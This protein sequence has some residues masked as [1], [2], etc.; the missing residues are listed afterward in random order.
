MSNGHSLGPVEPDHASEVLETLA[1]AGVDVVNDD[2]TPMFN[3]DS[4]AA[5][6]VDRG[7]KVI[8][9]SAAFASVE[10]ER[11]IDGDLLARASQGCPPATA[12]VELAGA[13]GALDS[14]IFAYARASRA[15]SWRLPPDVQAAAAQRPD[16][17]VILT[18]LVAQ[19][20]KPLE[21]VCRAYGLSGLQTRVALETIRTGSVKSAT[22]TLGVSYHTAREALAEAMRRVRAPRL[23]ALVNRLT[24]LAFGVLPESDGASILG[25]LWGLTA[26]QAAIAGLVAE[27]LSRGGVA[28]ALGLSEAVVKKELDRVHLLLQV[29]TGAAL[30]RKIVEANALRWL[31]TATGGDIGFVEPGAEPLQFVLRQDGSRIALS[32]YGPASGRPVLVVHSSMTSRIVARGLVRALQAAGYR[33]LSIDRPGFGLTDEVHGAR[34]GAHDPWATAAQDTLRVLEHLKVRGLDL[35]ARGGAQFVLA[36]EKA[37]PGRL[38]RVVL[39]NPD[40]H[41]AASTRTVGPYGVFK[42]ALM[43]NPAMISLAATVFMRQLT[44]ER[45]REMMQRAARGSP[46]DEIASRDPDIVRDYFRALRTF[47]T[48]RI[49]GHVNEQTEFARGSMPPPLAG[50]TDWRVLVAAHDTLHDPEQVLA[51]WQAVLPDARFEQAPD[52]GRLLALS[53]PHLVVEA[54]AS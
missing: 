17:V 51:Y 3:V 35:V 11:H 38:Q 50:T 49:G 52:A 41:S 43:R 7:G 22:R 8:C 53:H 6:L 15:M 14:A 1:A 33:A 54:L 32:D 2:T 21:A 26:R 20:A 44:H 25:D 24:S 34:P 37:A 40:P 36:L 9:A 48:G 16:H 4:I 31:T 45:V 12:V 10:G 29:S 39:I 27:G 19:A 23:P 13:D 46:P 30:A 18:S 28:G 47:A 5:A 42:Q